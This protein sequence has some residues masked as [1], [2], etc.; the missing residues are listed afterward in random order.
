MTDCNKLI[1]VLLSTNTKEIHDIYLTPLFTPKHDL[2]M[3]D[4]NDADSHTDTLNCSIPN[5]HKEKKTTP[6]IQKQGNWSNAVTKFRN[7]HT[8]ST[9]L[10]FPQARRRDR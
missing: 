10:A 3:D 4:N 1:H 2:D 8:Y 7:M 5:N 6:K 9:H